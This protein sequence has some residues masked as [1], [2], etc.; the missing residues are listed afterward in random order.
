MTQ[1]KLIIFDCDGVLVDSEPVTNAFLIKDLAGYG[2]HLSLADC[3][4]LFVGGTIAG[5]AVTARDM[6]ADL[7]PDWVPDYYRR[8]H[9]ELQKGVRLISGILDILNRVDAIGIANC[10]V[11]NGPPE[12][13]QITLGQHG[14][15]DRFEGRVFSAHTYGTAK[16]DP[17][18]LL[19]AARHFNTDPAD[20]IMID[21][22]ASGCTA[23]ANAGMPCIGYAERSDPERLA[24]TG[25]RVIRAMAELPVLLGL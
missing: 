21:D 4:D 23:A 25:A 16:P 11:S 18:L 22:S 9:V 1:P 15:W 24:A 12:K 6:G 5:V 3:D 7:P 20:C 19:I 8:V 14:L 17:E 10:V 2:L 13:M